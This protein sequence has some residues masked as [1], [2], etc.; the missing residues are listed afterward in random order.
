[1]FATQYGLAWSPTRNRTG[2]SDSRVNTAG[3]F[4]TLTRPVFDPTVARVIAP[5]GA[6]V[7]FPVVNA[8]SSSRSKPSLS[9]AGTFSA[10]CVSA[11]SSNDAMS[12][13]DSLKGLMTKAPRVGVP[14]VAVAPSAVHTAVAPA[15]V[16]P[17]H[18]FAVVVTF[19]HT[20]RH[21]FADPAFVSMMLLSSTSGSKY[22]PPVP[23][24]SIRAA[25]QTITSW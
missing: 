13:V 1:M 17:F 10:I 2:K 3:P 14:S 21:G 6:V 18:V 16:T 9:S 22:W 4:A 24:S 5:A 25:R 11:V 23:V 8:A 19:R 12:Q 7:P 15:D 20:R